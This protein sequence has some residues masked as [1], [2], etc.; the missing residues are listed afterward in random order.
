MQKTTRHQR[1]QNK[2]QAASVEQAEKIAGL[3]FEKR[4][5]LT[6]YSRKKT[7][8]TIEE[9]AANSDCGDLCIIQRGTEL[10]AQLVEVKRLSKENKYARF[11]KA[12]DFKRGVVIVDGVKQFEDKLAKG[13]TP[14][15]YLCFSE[16]MEC[17]YLIDVPKTRQYWKE[18]KTNGNE[19]PVKPYYVCST[20]YI[21]VHYTKKYV[22]DYQKFLTRSS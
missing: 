21:T 9:V 2:M 16:D 18:I 1:V 12:T 11:R 10:K 13:H 20:E 17:F 7:A 8:A 15:Y 19:N 14:I 3:I 4:G 22:P 5:Y 6:F